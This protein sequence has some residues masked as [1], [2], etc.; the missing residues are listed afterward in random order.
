MKSGFCGLVG[1]ASH[2]ATL[3]QFRRLTMF[4]LYE[5][6]TASDVG[7]LLQKLLLPRTL[8]NTAHVLLF[9][10][11]PALCAHPDDAVA[12]FFNAIAPWLNQTSVRRNILGISAYLI[13]SVCEN[14]ETNERPL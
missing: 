6:Q 13:C 7:G 12:P 11:F 4:E 10:V 8:G 1:S 3:G 5:A 14:P 9:K 2:G